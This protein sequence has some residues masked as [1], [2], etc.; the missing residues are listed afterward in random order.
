MP[1][2]RKVRVMSLT[3]S[4]IFLYSLMSVADNDGLHFN[5][6]ITMG[7]TAF[8]REQ[9]LYLL[10][11]RP[12]TTKMISTIRVTSGLKDKTQIPASSSLPTPPRLKSVVSGASDQVRF[13]WV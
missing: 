7:N 6:Q 8:Q 1:L 9:L 2:Q 12:T 3:L 5:L 4:E 13:S 11:G 10:Y